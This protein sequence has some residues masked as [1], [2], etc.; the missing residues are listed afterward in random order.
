MSTLVEDWH[1]CALSYARQ[2]FVWDG[3]HKL[4]SLERELYAL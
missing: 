3:G 1:F 4:A 2:V